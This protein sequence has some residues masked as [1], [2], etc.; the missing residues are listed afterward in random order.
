MA[1]V[2]LISIFAMI[3][4]SWAGIE[5][6]YY[7]GNKVEN[8]NGQRKKDSFYHQLFGFVFFNGVKWTFYIFGKEDNDDEYIFQR[9]WIIRCSLLAFLLSNVVYFIFWVVLI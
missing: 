5:I 8:K 4:Q 2:V 9:K 1:W 6:L 3:A 7:L